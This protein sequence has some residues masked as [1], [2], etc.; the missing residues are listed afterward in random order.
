MKCLLLGLLPFFFSSYGVGAQVTGTVTDVEGTP[1]RGVKV[2]VVQEAITLEVITDSEGRFQLDGVQ[3]KTAAKKKAS[4]KGP[5]KAS[6][7]S[8]KSKDDTSTG[9][10]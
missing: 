10:K 2:M 9:D 4:K 6:T 7:K 1:I 5:K 3:P 8:T